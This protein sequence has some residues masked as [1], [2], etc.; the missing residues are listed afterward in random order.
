M[1]LAASRNRS[2]RKLSRGKPA[3]ICQ[4][5]PVDWSIRQ[6]RTHGRGGGG[7]PPYRIRAWC[8][9]LYVETCETHPRSNLMA[10]NVR[11]FSYVRFRR[12]QGTWSG[13]SSSDWNLHTSSDNRLPIL[14]DDWLVHALKYFTA[15]AVLQIVLRKGL[16]ILCRALNWQLSLWSFYLI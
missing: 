15:L 9:L 13:N 11:I 10:R 16:W 12:R 6:T 8:L 2:R 3:M 7:M 14:S 1:N 4:F 5:S